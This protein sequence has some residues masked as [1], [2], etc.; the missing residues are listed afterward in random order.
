MVG[1]P[2]LNHCN[3]ADFVFCSYPASL[4]TL[5]AGTMPPT[6]WEAIREDAIDLR[7]CIGGRIS[8]GLVRKVLPDILE[9]ARKHATEEIARNVGL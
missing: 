3:A 4:G 2:I 6:E 9:T 1:F 7:F 5:F 8:C